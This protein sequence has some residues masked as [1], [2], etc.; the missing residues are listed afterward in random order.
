MSRRLRVAI[1][2]AGMGGLTAAAALSRAGVEVAVFEQARRFTRLGA[3]I[4]QSPNALKALRGL[5]LEDK[6]K[7]VAFQPRSISYR[8]AADGAVIWRRFTGDEYQERYGAPHLLL[9]RGDLH[10]AL[11]SITPSD[12]IHLDKKLVDYTED[13]SGV[14]LRFADGGEAR[15]DALIAADGVHSIVRDTILG[16]EQPRFSGRVAYRTTFPTRLLGDVEI[17]DATK[18]IAPDRHIVIYPIN[19]RRDELYFVTS[20]PEPDFATE[21][22]SAKGDMDVLRH[23]YR[24]FHPTVR[25]VLAACPEAHKWAIVERDPLTRWTSG[26]AVLI[27]DACHPMTPYLAQGAATAIEDAVVL[28]RCLSAVDGDG[29]AQAFRVFEATRKPRTSHIQAVSSLNSVER[30]RDEIPAVYRYD[31]WTEPLA[32]AA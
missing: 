7:A 10:E 4:Q 6:V 8:E 20:T 18:W 21:S 3:G 13:A 1:V 14:R 16:P 19:P 31:A 22:W 26:R 11:A 25:A 28:A 23:A 15:A 12:V 27:G 9:H 32:Q 2:G 30:L 29:V 5:G 24:D 17:E